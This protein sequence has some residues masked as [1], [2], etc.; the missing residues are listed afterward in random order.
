MMISK[1]FKIYLY[2]NFHIA[3]GAA[4]ITLMTY[5]STNKTVDNDYIALIFCA[6]LCLYN[7]HRIIASKIEY[8][9]FGIRRF[10]IAQQHLKF[11]YF[12]VLISALIGLYFLQFLKS[13]M[14]LVFF[15]LGMISLLYV[16]PIFNSKRILRDFPLTKSISVGIVWSAITATIPLIESG[17]HVNTISWLS[18]ERFLFITAITIPFDI[19]DLKVENENHVITI[20]GFFGVRNSKLISIGLLL[21]A[22]AILLQYTS[23]FIISLEAL[24]AFE[25]TYFISCILIIK[26]NESRGDWY[27]NGLMDGMV[28]LPLMLFLIFSQL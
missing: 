22:S 27:Y 13:Y 26:S 9:H 8:Q 24:I 4:S 12:L 17:F 19:R 5:L 18:L 6:T 25:I 1:F 11:H 23:V 2:G 20:P 14:F 21:F 28:I 7:L 3:L 10:F 15:I 16:F